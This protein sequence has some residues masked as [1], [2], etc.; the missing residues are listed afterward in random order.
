MKIFLLTITATLLSV[1]AF[2]CPVCEKQQPKVLQGISH[3]VGPQSNWDYAIVWATVAIVLLC[4][5][6][7]IKWLAKPGEKANNHIKRTVLDF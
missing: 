6:F 4:L 3:G 1:V 5:F 7:S 2:A